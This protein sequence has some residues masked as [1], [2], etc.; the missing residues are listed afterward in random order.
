MHNIYLGGNPKFRQYLIEKRDSNDFDSREQAESFITD[1]LL[2]KFKNEGREVDSTFF[3]ELD[4]FDISE[5][6]S[7]GFC[8]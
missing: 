7:C 8:D 5:T 2:E 1:Y 3:D 6:C 4:D